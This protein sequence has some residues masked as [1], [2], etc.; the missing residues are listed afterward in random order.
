MLLSIY[1]TIFWISDKDNI[2]F[3]PNFKKI[4]FQTVRNV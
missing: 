3:V 4:H 2:K 1:R